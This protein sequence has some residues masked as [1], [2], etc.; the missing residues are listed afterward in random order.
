MP[1]SVLPEYFFYYLVFFLNKY[2]FAETGKNITLY[3]KVYNLLEP[4]NPKIFQYVFLQR[5]YNAEF[6]NQTLDDE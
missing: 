3:Y 6:V 1:T 2:H 5:Q 4:I